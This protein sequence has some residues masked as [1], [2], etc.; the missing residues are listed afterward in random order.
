MTKTITITIALTLTM[1]LLIVSVTLNYM[2]Y[3]KQLISYK[4]V[5][6]EEE[7]RARTLWDGDKTSQPQARR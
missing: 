6:I 1:T 2:L 5:V 7:S 4:D 3:S